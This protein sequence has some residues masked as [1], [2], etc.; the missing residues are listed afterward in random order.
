MFHLAQNVAAQAPCVSLRKELCQSVKD[1]YQG[2]DKA[3]A[4]NKLKTIVERYKNKASKF[5]D[6]LEEHF[7]EGLTYMD[8]LEVY[9]HLLKKTLSR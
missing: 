2:L 1:I 3:D 7:I 9:Q 4:N 5:C 6:W 8:L